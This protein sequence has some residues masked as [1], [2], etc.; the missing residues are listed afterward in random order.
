MGFCAPVKDVV[1]FEVIIIVFFFISDSC[2]SNCN[3]SLVLLFC[4]FS[5]LQPV[6]YTVMC[7]KC[8]KSELNAR[9]VISHKKREKS[10]CKNVKYDLS[11]PMVSWIPVFFHVHICTFYIS[12]VEKQTC[13]APSL[14][15]QQQQQMK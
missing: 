12:T 2:W 6:K 8:R 13:P 9:Y 7:Q 3:M 4:V 1:N 11:D 14:T 5:R 10:S 15:S